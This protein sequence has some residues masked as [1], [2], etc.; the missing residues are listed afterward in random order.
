MLREWLCGAFSAVLSAFER[1]HTHLLLPDEE[2]DACR[3]HSALGVVMEGEKKIL[4]PT[5]ADCTCCLCESKKQLEVSINHY[6]EG[7]W[8]KGFRVL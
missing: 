3:G 5:P 7:I 8:L 1:T 2:A 4:P 6:R